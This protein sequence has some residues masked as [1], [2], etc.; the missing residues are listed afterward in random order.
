MSLDNATRTDNK[1]IKFTKFLFLLI[2]AI[3]QKG[4]PENAAWLEGK[5]YD[6]GMIVLIVI[7]AIAIKGLSLPA[8]F[9]IIKSDA[10]NVTRK[11]IP[12]KYHSLFSFF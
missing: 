2:L 4:A 7:S 8:I 3:R 11:V 10:A 5:E 1:N 6:D 9:F 12:H